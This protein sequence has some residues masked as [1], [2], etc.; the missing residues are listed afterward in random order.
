MHG[1]TVGDDLDDKE[2]DEAGDLQA[3]ISDLWGTEHVVSNLFKKAECAL[4][5]TTAPRPLRMFVIGSTT[6]HLNFNPSLRH[7]AI[8]DVG[9]KFCLPDL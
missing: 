6:I 3:A 2:A 4:L 5:S 7:Q 9:K 8:D 1:A